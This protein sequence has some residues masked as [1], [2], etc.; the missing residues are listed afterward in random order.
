MLRLRTVKA[1]VKSAAIRFFTSLPSPLG[2]GKSLSTALS[3]GA[4]FFVIKGQIFAVFIKQFS[5]Y[6]N[7]ADTVG[8]GGIA[9]KG[10]AVI[11]GEPFRFFQIIKDKICFVSCCDGT[12]FIKADGFGAF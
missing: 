11:A 9:K 1:A 2:P 7:M 5:I 4:N 8:T 6:K 10:I 12:H 3:F